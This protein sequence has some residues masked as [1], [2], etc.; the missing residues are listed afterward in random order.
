MKLTTQQLVTLFPQAGK[1]RALTGNIPMKFYRYFEAE[2]NEAMAE[3]GLKKYY[4]GGRYS[5]AVIGKSYPMTTV[6]C[7]AHSV[8]LYVK[9]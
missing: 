5:N 9:A 1:N 4:R 7:D 8:K 6:R 2:I 3:D